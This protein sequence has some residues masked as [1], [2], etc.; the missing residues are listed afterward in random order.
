VERVALITGIRRIGKEI[1]LELLRR[2]Y[3]LALV[4]RTSRE[5][6]EELSGKALGEGRRV[7]PLEADLSD[8]SAYSYVVERTVSELGRI[9]AF[10]HLA[11]PYMRTP[12]ETL[13]RE[14]LYLHFRP[15]VEAFLFI[16]LEVY[17][18]MLRNEG[19]IKGRIVAFGDWAVDHTP[20]RDYV[21][22]FISKGALHTAV[23]VL[24]KE[25]A[26]HVLV[27]CVALGP[28][29]RPEDMEADKW[30]RITA[31]TPLKREVPLRDVV[32]LVIYLLETEGMTGEII[33]L[34]SGRHIAG[35]GTGA[36]A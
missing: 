2:G 12:T 14:D 8:S 23:R 9:D 26:P 1:A 29:L 4:Y 30:R 28:T 25:F 31:G 10:I 19:G 7:L 11:S 33:R 22:Y 13:T 5:A 20:Y 36:V 34:D 17:R 16:S 21:A 35:S 32:A 27:N 6:V 15:I 3:D 18:I 24:A